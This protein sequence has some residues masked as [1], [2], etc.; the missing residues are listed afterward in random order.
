VSASCATNP[1][2]SKP[3]IGL[4]PKYSLRD[5]ATNPEKG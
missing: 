2:K 3:A 1:S 4:G 5:R